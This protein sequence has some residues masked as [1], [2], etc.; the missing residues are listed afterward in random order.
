M[1]CPVC[2]NVKLLMSER[3][4][5]EID[6]CPNCRGVWLDRGELDKIIDRS[7]DS[8]PSVQP[9][10]QQPQSQQSDHG[11]SPKQSYSHHEQHP[12]KKKRESFLG[13]LFD[14]D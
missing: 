9:A 12:Y 7:A 3:Q 4:G 8:T 2:N 5:I 14:F 1:D 6:Y 11:Y 13:E 10:P